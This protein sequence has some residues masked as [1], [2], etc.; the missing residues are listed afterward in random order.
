M[1]P[2][3]RDCPQ[4]FVNEQDS[5][6]RKNLWSVKTW[7]KSFFFGFGSDTLIFET[8]LKKITCCKICEMAWTRIRI[9]IQIGPNC[10]IGIQIQCTIGHNIWIHTQNYRWQ[11]RKEYKG[12]TNLAQSSLAG[13]PQVYLRCKDWGVYLRRFIKWALNKLSYPRVPSLVFLQEWYNWLRNWACVWHIV[14]YCTLYCAVY[15]T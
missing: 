11:N 3:C 13:L 5:D 2:S 1:H 7:G 12:K 15:T 9:R 8:D 4:T 6:Q 10:R 14:H